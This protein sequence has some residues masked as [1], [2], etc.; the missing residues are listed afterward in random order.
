MM[1]HPRWLFLMLLL[2]HPVQAAEPRV[3]FDPNTAQLRQLEGRWQLWASEQLVKDFGN[4]VKDAE[5]ALRVVRELQLTSVQQIGTDRPVVEYWLHNQEAPKVGSFQRVMRPFDPKKLKVVNYNGAWVLRDT[6]QILFHFGP[7]Q[8]DAE[9]TLAVCQKYGFN[10]VVYIGHPAPTMIYFVCDR[11]QNPSQNDPNAGFEAIR[12]AEILS[13]SAL[14]IT[15]VGYVGE[16]VPMDPRRLGLQRINNEFVIAQGTLILGRFGQ[17]E[18]AARD[19]LRALQDWRVTHWCRVGTHGVEFFLTNQRVPTG[20]PVMMRSAAFA[21]NGLRVTENN[22]KFAIT[23]GREVLY[24]FEGDRNEAE[25]V[26]A[27]IR[28]YRFDQ[29]ATMGH[30]LKP[31]IRI[32]AKSR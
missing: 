29:V 23:D 28:H 27:V 16:A 22:G 31:A 7:Y 21:A 1:M 4:A 18:A 17:Q 12:D 26:L 24:E 19:L 5:E 2:A 9:Q 32:L 20:V 25:R 11:S 8:Q 10:Q 13:R 15:G 3:V 30:P 6:R 14:T